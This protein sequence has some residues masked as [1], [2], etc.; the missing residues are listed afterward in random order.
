MTNKHLTIE[1]IRRR[2]LQHVG[3]AMGWTVGPAY[4]TGPD[5]A[6]PNHGAVWIEQAANKKYWRVVQMMENSTGERNLTDNFTKSELLAWMDGVLKA[7]DVFKAREDT[8]SQIVSDFVSDYNNG[9][10]PDMAR[11]VAAVK[12]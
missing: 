10:G 9:L 7:S 3:P 4:M 11:L 12:G 8:L 2:L 5:G 1:F 6:K